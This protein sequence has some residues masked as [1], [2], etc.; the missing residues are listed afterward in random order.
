MI[1][2]V[3]SN[4]TQMEVF[5]SLALKRTLV[6]EEL[7]VEEAVQ[8]LL[9]LWGSLEFKTQTVGT[10]ARGSKVQLPPRNQLA[11][12]ALVLGTSNRYPA[13]IPLLF[14]ED[15]Q[16]CHSHVQMLV[17]RGLAHQF[18]QRAAS[19]KLGRDLRDGLLLWRGVFVCVPVPWMQ[20]VCIVELK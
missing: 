4:D 6:V 1:R 10:S 13:G 16:G 7:N 12:E 2:A 9:W 3:E 5:V 18:Y 20:L 11:G 19:H 15:W 17:T 8:A 14:Q